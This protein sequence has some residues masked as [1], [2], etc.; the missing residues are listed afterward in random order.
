GPEGGRRK[1]FSRLGFEAADAL[2]EFLTLALDYERNETPSLQGFL[3]WLRSA[4]TQVKR[5]MAIARDE[6]RVMT[7][8]GAKGLEAPVV[9]LA[10]TT[11]PPKGV[12][13]PRLI[14]VPRAKAPPGAPPCIV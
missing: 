14:E 8:H 12:Y 9:I 3:N 10:D 11:T 2:D 13:P 6:V 4:D 1:I 5:D 7:V